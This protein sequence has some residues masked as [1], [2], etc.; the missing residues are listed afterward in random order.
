MV[1][2]LEIHPDP[3]EERFWPCEGG[4]VSVL[5]AVLRHESLFTTD[6]HVGNIHSSISLC[7]LRQ[8]PASSCCF[9]LGGLHCTVDL[10]SQDSRKTR[11]SWASCFCGSLSLFFRISDS[12]SAVSVSLN[13]NLWVFSQQGCHPA[14]ELPPTPPGIASSDR[15]NIK[16]TLL[17]CSQELYNREFLCFCCW[18]LQSLKQV[19]VCFCF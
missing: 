9:L 19:F 16:P 6:T 3:E 11:T 10:W 18:S 13:S 8:G 4:S 5:A 17:F 7:V 15:V 12:S 1:K 14:P 2:L